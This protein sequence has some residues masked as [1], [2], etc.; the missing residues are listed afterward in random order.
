MTNGV[1]GG[2]LDETNANIYDSLV[3]ACLATGATCEVDV[4]LTLPHSLPP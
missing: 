4:S 3:Q 1:A 2:V